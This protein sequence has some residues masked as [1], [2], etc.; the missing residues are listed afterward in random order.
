MNKFN[1]V[2]FL[3]ATLIILALGYV[4]YQ[5]YIINPG[6]IREL[7]D[8]PQGKTAARVMLVNLPSD[9][10]LPV[11]YLLKHEKYWAGADGRWWR[12]LREPGVNLSIMVAG[13]TIVVHAIAI[14]DDQKLTDEIFTELRPTAPRWVGAILVKFTPV[15]PPSKVQSRDSES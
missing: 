14:E 11:N 8:N 2:S 10:I 3:I 5:T 1:I 4:F 13:K 6:I 9:K 7:E 12:E 15:N